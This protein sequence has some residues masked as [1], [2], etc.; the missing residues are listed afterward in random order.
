MLLLL[1]SSANSDCTMYSAVGV[2][3]HPSTVVLFEEIILSKPFL[4]FS[5]SKVN[6]N[7]MSVNGMQTGMFFLMCTDELGRCVLLCMHI[8]YL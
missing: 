7:I 3:H 8:V 1:D 6:I 2:H 4:S 5:L